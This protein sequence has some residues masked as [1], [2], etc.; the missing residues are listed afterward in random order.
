MLSSFDDYPVHQVPVPVAEPATGDRNFYDRYFF[1]GYRP[2]GEV[3]FGG[4]MGLYPNRRVID[5]AFSVVHDGV[6]HNVYASG[7]A[8]LDRATTRVGPIRIEVIEPMRTLRLVVEDNDS[9]VAADVTFD[10]RAVVVQEQRQTRTDANVLIMDVTRFTQAGSWRG[11]VEVGGSRVELD[12]ARDRGTRDRSWGV[13][14]V[15]EPPG[16]AP[17]GG[18]PQIMWLWGPSHFDDE[19]LYLAMFGDADGRWWYQ[20]TLTAP[21]L[22]GPDTP[23]VDPAAAEELES[24][25]VELRWEP[26]TRRARGATMTLHRRSGPPRTVVY[27]PIYTFQMAGIGYSHPVWAHG[28]WHGELEVGADSWRLDGIDP[29]ARHNLHIQQLCRV[30][31]DGRPGCG[32]LEQIALGPHR[33]SGLTGLLDPYAG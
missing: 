21:I 2:D 6:Q 15:G 28:T 17:P 18:L 30:T 8:P 10:A 26:G 23:T 1:N 19:C 7:R 14:P 22:G 4:A 3:Y 9:G 31:I 12:P 29:M 16:G 27:E 25:D 11:W 20:H 33:P 13:R 5:A 24:V 32:I